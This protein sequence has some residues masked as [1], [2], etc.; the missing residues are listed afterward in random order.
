MGMSTPISAAPP[1]LADGHTDSSE[2]ESAAAAP[3]FARRRLRLGISGVGLSVVSALAWLALLITGV[4]VPPPLSS[5]TGSVPTP[6]LTVVQAVTA[7]IVVFVLHALLTVVF[8]YR[9]GAVVVRHRPTVGRVDARMGT[10][11]VRSGPRCSLC[12]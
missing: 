1:R 7:V 3:T 10:R 5:L 6:V 8:E 9:G 11:R 12:S 2:R 4:V